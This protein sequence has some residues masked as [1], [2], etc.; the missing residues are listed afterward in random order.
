MYRIMSN[1]TEIAT[2]E[3]SGEA[4]N[5]AVAESWRFDDVVTVHGPTG[6]PEYMAQHGA[7]Y[8]LEHIAAI[9]SVTRK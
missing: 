2:T 7:L 3:T 9:K 5:L 6:G 1:L 8:R 4:I